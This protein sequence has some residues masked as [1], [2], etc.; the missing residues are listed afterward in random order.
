MTAS[1]PRIDAPTTTS[2]YHR[3]RIDGKGMPPDI[4]DK[5]FN[6]SFTTNKEEGKGRA[7]GS[8]WLRAFSSNRKGH[9][10]IE[11]RVGRGTTV[12]LYLPKSNE[13]TDTAAVPSPVR[14]TWPGTDRV[15]V[16]GQRLPVSWPMA[17]ILTPAAGC[18]RAVVFRHIAT[19]KVVTALGFR[20]HGDPGERDR[21]AVLV[22]IAA[23]EA[24]RRLPTTGLAHLLARRLEGS[25]GTRSFCPLANQ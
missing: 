15:E 5:V 25:S 24:A 2:R 12:R 20:P 18:R 13:S 10:R 9:V 14:C 22:T 11:S 4:L 7:Q 1:R 16:R 21:M 3:L 17:S 8:A 19:D 23:P 6:P